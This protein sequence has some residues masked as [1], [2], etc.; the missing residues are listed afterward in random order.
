MTARMFHGVVMWARPVPQ[1]RRSCAPCNLWMQRVRCRHCG[2]V[3]ASPRVIFVPQLSWIQRGITMAPAPQR[4]VSHTS[5]FLRARP[6]SSLPCR[7]TSGRLPSLQAHS[8]TLRRLACT[9]S[10]P[11]YR[12]LVRRLLLVFLR[13]QAAIPDCSDHMQPYLNHRQFCGCAT[14]LLRSRAYGAYRALHLSAHPLL[15]APTT[16]TLPTGV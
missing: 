13:Q 4:L 6:C 16:P 5:P 8:T 12:R 14:P 11:V 15:L 9:Q 10:A 3:Q 7:P 2:R 1:L